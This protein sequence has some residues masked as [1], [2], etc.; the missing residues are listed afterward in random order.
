MSSVVGL[1]DGE[2]VTQSSEGNEQAFREILRRYRDKV[3]AICI[4]MLRNRTEA[5]EAAQD[6]FVKIYFHLRDFDQA[7]S[8]AAWIAGISI[9][10]CRDRL[11]KRSRFQKVFREATESEV[12]SQRT[13]RSDDYELKAKIEAVENA[14][15]RLPEKLREVLVLRAYADYSYEE[16]AEILKTRVGTVM[17]R[18]HRSREKLSE[19]LRMDDES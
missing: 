19:M 17:S 2:L 3:L 5:E 1:S 18:L 7:R 14:I 13:Q 12:E 4:R 11:R 15:E 9:N 8:F 10:E 6:S 16:I